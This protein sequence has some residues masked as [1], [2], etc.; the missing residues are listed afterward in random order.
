MENK[1]NFDV[2]ETISKIYEVSEN[3][4]LKQTVFTKLKS[5]LG[6][7]S[8]YFKITK[9]QAFFLAI[10][11][12]LNYK[13]TNTIN[14]SDIGVHLDCNP[15]QLLKYTKD[16]DY[17]CDNDYM[18]K[19][20]S[21]FSFDMFYADSEYTV[22]KSVSKAI[23]NN[24]EYNNNNEV[25][26]NSVIDVLDKIISLTELFNDEKLNA[27]ILRKKIENLISNN[28]D[29]DFFKNILRL[30]ISYNYQMMYYLLIWEN[31]TG[32][33]TAD[34]EQSI[35]KFIKS[36]KQKIKLIQAFNNK[37][38]N[39]L[40][41]LDL[42]EIEEDTFIN[43]SSMKLTEKSL[44]ILEKEDIKLFKEL[45]NKKSENTILHSEI[46]KIKMYYNDNENNQIAMLRDA[47]RDTKFKQLQTRLQQKNLPV[48]ITALFYGYPGTGK[49][50]SVLQLAKQ[51]GRDIIK[52]DIS[53]TKSKWFGDTEKI[54]KKIF[55]NYK[56]LKESSKKTPVLLFNEADAIISKRKDSN[57]SN[58]AQTENAI[59]NIILEE[60]ENFDGILIATTN[61][62]NNFDTAFE[63]RFL[64]KVEF[65]KPKTEVK[66]KIWK[67]KLK[68]L[69]YSDCV[70][71]A[72]KYDFTGGQIN[73][74]V[75]KIEMAE[76]LENKKITL[77]TIQEFCDEETISKKTKVKIGFKATS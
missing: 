20:K 38:Q 57:S 19:E 58:V 51:T 23:I 49:T 65:H 26:F 3:S 70:K 36:P 43:N 16:I 45:S 73:N 40:V 53:Q 59:Q 74:I 55:T 67:A 21:S 35:D 52:V 8:K 12:A 2:L 72:E 18:I 6:L 14:F 22:S 41:T 76:V 75:R 37:K 56:R 61:L 42:I 32:S 13:K 24:I 5:E 29:L 69:K 17:L 44:R 1:I 63:R 47:L 64:F 15:M 71:L 68:K 11:F 28:K 31:L 48:G 77:K 54:I 62:A 46:A 33:E 30:N 9:T 60:L 27:I 34:I 39:K 50:E 66:A 25:K 10:I 7:L 4:K